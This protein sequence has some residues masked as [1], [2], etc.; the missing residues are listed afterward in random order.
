MTLVKLSDQE[1]AAIIEAC[2][3]AQGELCCGENFPE[4]NAAWAQWEQ[5]IK[6]LRDGA[7]A[8]QL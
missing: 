7:T 3:V 1:V 6:R 4:A 5:I 8:D 2:E